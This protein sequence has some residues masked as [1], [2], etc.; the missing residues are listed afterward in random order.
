MGRRGGRDQRTRLEALGSLC[1][2]LLH[3]PQPKS[4]PSHA[5]IAA[6]QMQ[7]AMHTSRHG[8]E[9]EGMMVQGALAAVKI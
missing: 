4:H 5:H 2:R 9:H 8:Q 7:S 1:D 3:G 6:L